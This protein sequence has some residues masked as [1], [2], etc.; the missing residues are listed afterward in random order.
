[1]GRPSLIGLEIDIDGGKVV[2]SRIG[3]NAVIV[4]EGTLDID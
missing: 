1:M 2:A 3:G 4:A